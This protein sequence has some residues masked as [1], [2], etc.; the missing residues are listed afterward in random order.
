MTS[1]LIL[2]TGNMANAISMFLARASV[3]AKAVG[4]G[5]EWDATGFDAVLLAVPYTAHDHIVRDHSATLAGKIIVDISNPV[6]LDPLTR[7]RDSHGSAAAALAAALP[8]SRIVKAFNTNYAGHLRT[9]SVDGNQL[10]VL[11]AS[12]HR[13]AAAFVLD[14]A[15]HAGAKT[16]DVGPLDRAEALEG[17]CYLQ[18]SI[19]F[20]EPNG[21]EGGFVFLE[22][23]FLQDGIEDLR[24]DS[25]HDADLPSADA[26]FEMVVHRDDHQHHYV[27]RLN[28]YE[29]ATIEFTQT[30]NRIVILTTTVVPEFRGRG[31]A[32]ELI[33]YALDDVRDRGMHVTVYCPLVSAFISQN[34][35]YAGLVDPQ[36]PGRTSS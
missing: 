8:S 23:R 10:T 20:S 35:G 16:F 22:D 6:T 29:V 21:S 11:A 3:D 19:T 7:V 17:L 1:I 12:D 32:A 33:A 15:A 13:D 31:I 14:L 5:E 26:E 25:L 34:P 2:G 30:D 27:A 28:E 24:N 9:G 36:H 4:R 18:M